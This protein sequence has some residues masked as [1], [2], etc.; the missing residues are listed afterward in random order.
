MGSFRRV[1]HKQNIQAHGWILIKTLIISIVALAG[2]FAVSQAYVYAEG[3]T[4]PTAETTSGE[5]VVIDT[6]GGDDVAVVPDSYH[7]IV[8]PCDNM[9][10]LVRRSITLYDD[11]NDAIKLT[12]AEVIFI[13][14]NIVQE[15]GPRLIDIDENFEVDRTLIEKY[16][17]QIPGLS[18]TAQAAWSRYAD[19]ATFELAQI[20]PTNV[21]LND[22][23]SLDTEYTPP[24]V[25]DT[26]DQTTDSSST[27]AYWWLIGLVA[28]VAVTLILW[29]S[30]DKNKK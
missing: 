23:G 20:T 11:G 25:Q 4:T 14:T 9:T 28:I 30:Q 18:Q 2:L 19:T 21:P 8:Q 5:T 22:D 16:V 17:E 3:E 27:P 29:P 6:T 15:M 24:V 7:Y 1:M 10:K 13:E 12:E 26:S